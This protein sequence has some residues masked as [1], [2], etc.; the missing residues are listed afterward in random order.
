MCMRVR[1]IKSWSFVATLRR[2]TRF[3]LLNVLPSKDQASADIVHVQLKDLSQKIHTTIQPVFVSQR[4]EQDIKLQETKP[5]VVNQQCLVYK[6]K[7]DLCNGGYVGFTHC[8][9]HQCVLEY[10]NSTL[11][12]GKHFCD[13]HLLAPTDHTKNFSVLKKYTNK[14]GCFPYKMFLFK[15]WD[16]LSM[17]IQTQF[18][19]RF[20]IRFLIFIFTFNLDF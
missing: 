10:R 16:Q 20:L 6:F 4:I 12:I 9:L 2:S 8:H 17:C 1:S 11:L 18:M 14:F 13:K 19:Q 7:C 15:N 3:S 5:P